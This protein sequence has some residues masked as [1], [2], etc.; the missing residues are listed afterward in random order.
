[1]YLGLMLRDAEI[2]GASL[3]RRNKGRADEREIRLLDFRCSSDCRLESWRPPT[4]RSDDGSCTYPAARLVP[5]LLLL[6][7]RQR[8]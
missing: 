2:K 5:L 4:M 7:S 6:Q 8:L 3:H 1:M